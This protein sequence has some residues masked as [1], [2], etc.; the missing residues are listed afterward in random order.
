MRGKQAIVLV[1]AG[2]GLGLGWRVRADLVIDRGRT[3]DWRPSTSITTEDLWHQDTAQPSPPRQLMA[4][5]L[6]YSEP[7]AM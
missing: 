4:I 1:S 2:L 5:A 7:V 6:Q 3:G